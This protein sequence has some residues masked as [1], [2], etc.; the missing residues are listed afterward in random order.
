LII[1]DKKIPD[2]AKQNLSRLGDLSLFATE[3]IVYDAISGHPDIFFFQ[4]NGE[5]V[6]SP[7]LPDEYIDLLNKNLVKYKLGKSAT[8]SGYPASA[9]YNAAV[10]CDT[11]VHNLD[12]TDEAILSLFPED[13]RVNIKQGYGRCSTIPLKGNNAITSDAGICK[14]LTKAGYNALYVS[15]EGIMLP[16]FKNGF[17][18]G[19]CGLQGDTVYFLGSLEKKIH[20]DNIRSFLQNLNYNIVELCNTPLFDGGSIMFVN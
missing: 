14:T 15:P 16:G 20:G 7:N 3:G 13:K 5:M 12:I 2:E 1:A 17:I 4:H 19:T 10:I 18:G 6:V 11:L 9:H 8:S